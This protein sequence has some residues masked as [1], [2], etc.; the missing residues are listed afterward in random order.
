MF[1]T[2]DILFPRYPKYYRK[3]NTLCRRLYMYK[4][5]HFPIIKIMS[6]STH[7]LK[8]STVL[9]RCVKYSCICNLL[10]FQGVV[11]SFCNVRG[12][13]NTEELLK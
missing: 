3:S 10:I 6:N 13:R 7:S 8:L 12:Q 11:A 1:S 9:M 5:M 2:K 4:E